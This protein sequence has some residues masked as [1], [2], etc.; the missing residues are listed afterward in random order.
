MKKKT[1]VALAV[2]GSLL[3]GSIGAYASI[4]AWQGRSAVNE[5]GLKFK[6]LATGTKKQ[7]ATLKKTQTDLRNKQVELDNLKGRYNTLEQQS[8]KDKAT[9]AQLQSDIEAKTKE[10]TDLKNQLS[11]LEQTSN[12]ETQQAVQDLNQLNK[13][14][15]SI[16]GDSDIKAVMNDGKTHANGTENKYDVTDKATS[17]N[18]N[19]K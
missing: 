7:T 14:I 16:A 2:T 13:D 5:I 6:Q 17:E 12:E 11:Q 3:F 10:I 15:N 9:I 8:T 4:E 18:T 19:I 1:I